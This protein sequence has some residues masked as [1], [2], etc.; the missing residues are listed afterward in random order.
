[1]QPLIVDCKGLRLTSEER[2]LFKQIDPYGFILFGRNCDNPEQVKALTDEMREVTGRHNTPILI[3][4]E[5]GRVARLKPPHWSVFPSARK[6]AEAK[7]DSLRATYL[8]ARLMALELAAVGITVDCLPLADIPVPGAHDIIGDRAFGTDAG[9]VTTHARAQANGLMDGG[10]VPVL[11]HIPGH[12]RAVVDSHEAL[13]VVTASLAELEATDFLPFKS[14]SDLPMGMTAHVVYTALDA[15]HMATLS[16]KA[17]RYIRH[18]IGFDNLL[19]SDALWMKS[20]K[21]TYAERAVGALSAGCDVV[22]HCNGLS[23]PDMDVL[24]ASA[25]AC[26]PLSGEAL[27]RAVRAMQIRATDAAFDAKEAKEEVAGFLGS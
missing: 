7:G 11:K 1:M 22:L 2:A 16:P 23:D 24:R 26:A 17:I 8:S 9:T 19:M 6:L 13:P 14:L 18:D 3:D 25:D 27:A 21:G 12:G 4:Q 5:G 15:D 10:I 20:M